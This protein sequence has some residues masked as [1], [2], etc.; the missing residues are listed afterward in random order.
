MRTLNIK[1][2]VDPWLSQIRIVYPGR[3]FA[4]GERDPAVDPP[5]GDL[6]RGVRDADG[7]I[8]S[9]WEC[10]Y[11]I[12]RNARPLLVSAGP[13]GFMGDLTVDPTDIEFKRALDNV[14]SYEPAQP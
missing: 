10:R 12:C 6:Q 9:E 3:N 2:F 11:G 4:D 7:S 1:E 14:Y 13:D 5:L 8:R